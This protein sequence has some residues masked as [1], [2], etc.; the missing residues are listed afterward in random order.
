M[1]HRDD[2]KGRPRGTGYWAKKW[3][4]HRDTA[5]A[6]LAKLHEK[7]GANVVWRAGAQNEYTASEASLA[8]VG[9]SRRPVTGGRDTAETAED[10]DCVTQEQLQ[11]AMAHL[12]ASFERRISE[13][14]LL[15]RPR[16]PR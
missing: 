11:R 2:P 16:V 9:Q 12:L 15:R 5:R 14:V 3:G 10:R 6:V 1:N 4:V 7:Y 13:E 8:S